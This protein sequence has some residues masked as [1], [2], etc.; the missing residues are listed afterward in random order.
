[1]ITTYCPWCDRGDYHSDGD[2]RS[3]C[4]VLCN[5]L[6]AAAPQ[7]LQAHSTLHSVVEHHTCLKYLKNSTKHWISLR[8]RPIWSTAC[9]FERIVVLQR[10]SLRKC[11]SRVQCTVRETLNWP[12]EEV[13]VWW[14]D[15]EALGH[16]SSPSLACAIVLHCALC[17][18]T[19]HC[20]P[21]DLFQ[22]WFELMC[23][24]SGGDPNTV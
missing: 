9:E 15:Q 3:C 23:Q 22:L 21:L 12:L 18:N 10:K 5:S 8:S 20:N 1:M 16:H 4:V 6:H 24:E 7:V 13:G 14:I 19:R 2:R 17:I 11:I